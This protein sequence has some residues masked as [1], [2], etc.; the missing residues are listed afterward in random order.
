MKKLLFLCLLFTSS[1]LIGGDN[2]NNTDPVKSAVE[3]TI[4]KCDSD[5]ELVCSGCAIYSIPCSCGGFNFT[6]ITYQ[7]CSNCPIPGYPTSASS[8]GAMFCAQYC[9]RFNPLP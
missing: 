6:T 7:W 4:V 8:A 3:K 5:G 9:S 1:Y 2:T